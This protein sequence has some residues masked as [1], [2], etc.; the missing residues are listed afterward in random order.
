MKVQKN[1]AEDEDLFKIGGGG[2]KRK[3]PHFICE[4][5]VPEKT[6]FLIK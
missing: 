5:F 1:Q 2:G 4:F 3:G 6:E